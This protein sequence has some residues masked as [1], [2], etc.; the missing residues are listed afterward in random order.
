MARIGYRAA[1]IFPS[2]ELPRAD[3]AGAEHQHREHKPDH[4]TSLLVG[5][6]FHVKFPREKQ[7]LP[8]KNALPKSALFLMPIH[9]FERRP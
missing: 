6:A 2:V 5:P 3:R 9:C 1:L 4:C 8:I 7:P